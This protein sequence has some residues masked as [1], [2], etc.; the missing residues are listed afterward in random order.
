MM[1]LASFNRRLKQYPATEID[2]GSPKGA[3]C[4]TVTF[5]PGMQPISI[6]LINIS[7]FSNECITAVFPTLISDSFFIISKSIPQVTYIV[8]NFGAL[9]KRMIKFTNHD[10]KFNS[11]EKTRL[12]LF[13]EQ[14]IKKESGSGCNI[15]YV[16]CSD[17][18]LLQINKQFLDHDFYTDIITFDLGGESGVN[19]EIYISVDRVK[20]NA[21]SFNETYRKEML[22]VIFHG[23][24]HL[25]GYRDK[26]KSEITLMREKETEYLK[27][28]EKTNPKR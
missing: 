7:S 15:Q 22:R 26:T 23:A 20:E 2:I 14:L 27:R 17:E 9:L 5:S 18:C 10:R 21:G 1:F 11:S 6:S 16:F 25:C 4:S 13:I 8:T 24:L 3:T 12:K 28:F 19:A